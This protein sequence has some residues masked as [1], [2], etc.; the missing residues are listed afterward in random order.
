CGCPSICPAAPP[1]A[2]LARTGR[3]AASVDAESTA[4]C[5]AK[6]LAW[7]ET[8]PAGLEPFLAQHSPD[9]PPA[10]GEPDL[11]L[12]S[13]CLLGAAGIRA[14]RQRWNMAEM[15]G[16]RARRAVRHCAMADS[17]GNFGIRVS[18]SATLGSGS[19]Q[20]G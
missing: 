2:G 5:R 4:G 11:P 13:E 8:R 6:D 10:E 7:R 18:C 12:D 16:Y 1:E 19:V 9:C 20:R 15:A 14:S 3:G 17:A